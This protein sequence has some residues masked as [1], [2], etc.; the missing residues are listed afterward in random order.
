MSS[1]LANALSTIGYPLLTI[2]VFVVVAL[3]NYESFREASII[4]A[5]VLG[6]VTIPLSIKMY[7][8]SKRGTY[9]NFDV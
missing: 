2:S 7:V 1:K 6:F 4:S 5:L 8:G 3:F 9:T